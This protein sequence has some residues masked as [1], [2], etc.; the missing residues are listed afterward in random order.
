MS[1]YVS[2]IQ[3]NQIWVSSYWAILCVLTTNHY[4]LEI[5]LSDLPLCLV[6]RSQ[7]SWTVDIGPW[8]LQ[9]LPNALPLVLICSSYIA[10]RMNF[11]KILILLFIT[12]RTH[13]KPGIY[14]SPVW[15]LLTHSVPALT[16]FPPSS[17][18]A[19]LLSPLVGQAKAFAPNV[20]PMSF[21]FSCCKPSI[22]FLTFNSRIIVTSSF[23]ILSPYATPLV[24]PW[25]SYTGFC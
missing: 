19:Q 13:A 17:R 9:Q 1:F 18:Q 5:S 24:G 23:S 3:P 7:S 12:C 8:I 15:S 11:P 25:E 4:L 14:I 10:S 20:G 16:T 6:L 2:I 21:P 22:W